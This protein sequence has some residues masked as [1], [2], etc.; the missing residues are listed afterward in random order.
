MRPVAIR[1][2][3]AIFSC[4]GESLIE[5][6][7]I[8]LASVLGCC[9]SSA[10]RAAWQSGWEASSAK[11]P[12]SRTFSSSGPVNSSRSVIKWNVWPYASANCGRPPAFV[13]LGVSSRVEGLISSKRRWPFCMVTR[14]SGTMYEH[15]SVRRTVLEG[16]SSKSVICWSCSRQAY[17]MENGCSWMEVTSGQAAKIRAAAASN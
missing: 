12:S 14:K 15:R 17:Q 13:A 11:R 3:M 10:S 5:K 9:F 6:C 2:K 8:R 1:C 16:G 7:S 4:A